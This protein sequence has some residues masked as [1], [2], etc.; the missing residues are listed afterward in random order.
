MLQSAPVRRSSGLRAEELRTPRTTPLLCLAIT[1]HHSAAVYTLWCRESSVFQHITSHQ[2]SKAQLT[3]LHRHHWQTTSDIWVIKHNV[4]MTWT[5][6]DHLFASFNI[7]AIN[8]VPEQKHD[9]HMPGRLFDEYMNTINCTSPAARGS[10][11]DI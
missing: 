3:L 11:T 7:L 6:K 10:V 5:L 4:L 8:L 9:I 1:L 2:C